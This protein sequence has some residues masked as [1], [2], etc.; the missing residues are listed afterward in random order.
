MP[1]SKEF[2]ISEIWNGER[3]KVISG[4]QTGADRAGLDAA[5][6]VGLPIGGWCPAG[7]RSDDRKI[8]EKYPLIETPERNYLQR[9]EWNARAADATL[10]MKLPPVS[11]SGTLYT[12]KFCEKWNTI[13]VDFYNELEEFGF[14]H[15]VDKVSCCRLINVAGPRQAPSPGLYRWALK[16]L[17]SLFGTLKERHGIR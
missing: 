6:A 11:S 16:N 1:Q 10:I 8:P 13:L 3:L 14:D 15:I 2:D 17:K 4:G 7:R 5:L 9:T 12:I